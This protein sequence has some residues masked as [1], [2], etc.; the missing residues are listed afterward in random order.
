MTT[1]DLTEIKELMIQASN[2]LAREDVANDRKALDEM[3]IAVNLLIGLVENHRHTT[4]TAYDGAPIYT[5][6]MQAMED[7]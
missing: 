2:H 6:P 4:D 7:R 3:R 1:H 5:G